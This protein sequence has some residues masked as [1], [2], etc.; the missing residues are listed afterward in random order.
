MHYKD[1][2][3][4]KLGDIIQ[5]DDGDIGI[6]I[7]GTIGSDYCSTQV[8]KFTGKKRD[9]HFDQPGGPGFIGHLKDADG[10]VVSTAGVHVALHNAMQT[11]EMVKIGHMDIG[12][13]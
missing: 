5:H 12:H 9:G 8:V 10:K 4:A 11:R 6:V 3:E 2:T 7:G 1:G 13:G